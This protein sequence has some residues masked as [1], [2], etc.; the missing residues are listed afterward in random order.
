MS[1]LGGGQVAV[2]AAVVVGED[3]ADDVVAAVGRTVDLSAKLSE[4]AMSWQVAETEPGS[5]SWAVLR[6]GARV[7][8]VRRESTTRGR[9][10][11]L[12]RLDTGVP[13]PAHGDL[14]AAAG[15]TLWRTRDLA[16]AAI[17]RRWTHARPSAGADTPARPALVT[18]PGVRAVGVVPGATPTG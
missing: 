2:T 8:V 14:A 6:D 17:A 3:Q 1:T 15:S 16:A 5:G 4:P 11:W 18:P 12:A 9:R 7:G 13:L 10:G